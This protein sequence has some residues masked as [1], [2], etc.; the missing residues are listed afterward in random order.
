MDGAALT[1]LSKIEVWRDGE[2]IFTFFNP[3]PGQQGLTMTDDAP[4]NGQHTYAVVPFNAAGQGQKASQTVFTGFDR[5]APPRSITLTDEADHV[6]LSW[7]PPTTVGSY[8][9]Y[10]EVDDVRYDI[11]NYYPERSMIMEYQTN[12]DGTSIDIPMNTDEGS[13]RMLVYAMRSVT[14]AGTGRY[15]ISNYIMIGA[16]YSLPFHE[17]VAGG[18][19]QNGGWLQGGTGDSGV[20]TSASGAQDADGGCLAWKASKT[21]DTAWLKSG[22]ISLAS[23]AT[24][25]LTF[26]YRVTSSMADAQLSVDALCSGKDTVTLATIPLKGLADEWVKAEVRLNSLASERYI[27]LV[28]NF[29][30]NTTDALI[31]LDNITIA[32][33]DYSCIGSIEASSVP[34]RLYRVD[35]LAI[36]QQGSIPRG[37]YVVRKDGQTRKVVMK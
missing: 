6:T 37:V 16:P 20:G 2:L 8:G 17:S 13:Q 18:R 26:Y 9:G 4:D 31:G 27:Q 33:D 24:P 15:G 3:E 1:E 7:L 10:C 28:F 32:H 22:K 5:P 35:G 11:Y 29:Q 30:S 25:L 21:G 36:P 19:T 23:T 14:E 12:Y 34:G